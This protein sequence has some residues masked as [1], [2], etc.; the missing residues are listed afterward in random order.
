MFDRAQI[1]RLAH[2]HRR[3]LAPFQAVEAGARAY[4]RLGLEIRSLDASV[5]EK[6]HGGQRDRITGGGQAYYFSLQVAKLSISGL[7]I[8]L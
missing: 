3:A 7:T 1:F 6:P 5:A 8:R 4:D 2:G